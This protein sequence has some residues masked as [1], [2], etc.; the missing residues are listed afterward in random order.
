MLPVVVSFVVL[1]TSTLLVAESNASKV[2][3]SG[4]VSIKVGE[5][6]ALIPP[7]P[8]V[9][10]KPLT[11]MRPGDA[12][13]VE[14]LCEARTRSVNP[15]GGLVICAPPP[16]Y[17]PALKETRHKAAITNT[18]Y[19]RAD[20][21]KRKAPN[22]RE[23]RYLGAKQRIIAEPRL[24]HSPCA[25]TESVYL[26]CFFLRC[27][28]LRSSC[29]LP[30]WRMTFWLGSSGPRFSATAPWERCFTQKVFSSIAAMTS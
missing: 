15:L 20:F 30:I 28:S 9:S 25:R 8:T 21:F 6:P 13:G 23:S 11:M 2:A 17:A 19:K 10:L 26:S 12:E 4:E 1:T 3:R 22:Y 27:K 5:L 18:A 14:A 16:P 7:L 29:M 24:D